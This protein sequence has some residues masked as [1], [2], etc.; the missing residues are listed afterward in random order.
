[1]TNDRRGIRERSPPQYMLS[2]FMNVADQSGLVKGRNPYEANT[3]RSFTEK[4]TLIADY[5]TIKRSS[6]KLTF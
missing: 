3:I 4:G 5:K 2:L 6:K 1:M